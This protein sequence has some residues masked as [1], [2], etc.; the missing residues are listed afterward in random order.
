MAKMKLQGA[1]EAKDYELQSHGFMTFSQDNDEQQFDVLTRLG[2]LPV[3]KVS[4]PI[5]IS[6]KLV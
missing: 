1:P 4:S 3:L 2:K 6:R 5:L